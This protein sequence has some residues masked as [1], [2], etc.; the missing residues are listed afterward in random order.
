M[1]HASFTFTTVSWASWMRWRLD[2]IQQHLESLTEVFLI[3]LADVSGNWEPAQRERAVREV[4]NFTLVSRGLAQTRNPL[5]Q[6]E[7]TQLQV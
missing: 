4:A 1:A 3:I 7:R 2:L 6:E 5:T